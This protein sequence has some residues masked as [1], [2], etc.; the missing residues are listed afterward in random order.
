MASTDQQGVPLSR[1]KGSTEKE[2]VDSRGEEDD[3]DS[4]PGKPE[5]AETAL[6]DKHEGELRTTCSNLVW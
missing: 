5:A 4:D 2:A 1:G 3:P 6:G